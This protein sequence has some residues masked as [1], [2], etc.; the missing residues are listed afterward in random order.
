MNTRFHRLGALALIVLGLQQARAAEAPAYRTEGLCDGLPAITSLKVAPA[1]CLAL[2]A[3]RLGHPRGVLALDADHL[4]VTD[5]GRWD[6]PSGRLL[7]LRRAPGGPFEVQVLLKGLDRP[8]GIRRD[9]QGRVLLAEASRISRVELPGA[10]GGAAQLQPLITGLPAVGRHPLK[11][12]VIDDGGA[13]WVNVGAPT[14]HCEAF[15]GVQAGTPQGCAQTGGPNS[16]AAVWKFTLRPGAADAWTGQ[17]FAWGLRNSMGLAVHPA[18]GQLW[19]AENSRDTLPGG[20]YDKAAPPDELNLVQAGRHYGWPHC[21]GAGLLD[22]SFGATG[23]QGFTAPA[24][25]LP[26]HAAPLGM[27]FYGDAGPPAWRGSLVM[28]WHGYQPAGQRL[29]AW[30]FDARHQ[31]AGD[32]QP[33]ISGWSAAPGRHP[34]G[35]PTDVAEGPQGRLWITEDRNGTLLLLAPR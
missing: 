17:P 8:H 34:M 35:A 26:A 13:I 11:A 21:T 2:A 18:S 9:A 4:L 22:N 32:P 16:T 33:L 6:A 28:A 30:R 1:F 14:D 25:L 12:F 20:G 31:P 3:S 19:Q 7:S 5:L 27:L 29:V 24:R 23:C 15:D 10:G